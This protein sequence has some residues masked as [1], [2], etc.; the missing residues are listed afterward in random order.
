[1]AQAQ[2]KAKDQFSL[3]G[4]VLDQKEGI[5]YLRYYDSSGE[6]VRD[7]AN[8]KE[9]KFSFTGK[10]KAPTV[11]SV[12]IQD[13]FSDIFI[14]PVAMSGTFTKD[15]FPKATVRGSKTQDLYA[16][17]ER[18]KAAIEAKYQKTIDLLR[19]EARGERRKAKIDSLREQ[20]APYF[21]E[22][23]QAEYVFMDKHPQSYITPYLLKMRIADLPIDSLDM[24]YSRL[25]EEVQ[26]T[27][28]GKELLKEIEEVRRGSTDSKAFQF[29]SVGID[30]KPLNL[31]DYQGKYVLLDF[32]G[33]WCA[34]CRKG[35]PH[36]VDLYQEYKDKGIEFISVAC[37]DT[38]AAWRKAVEKDGIGIW[39]HILDEET[40]AVAENQSDEII[41]IWKQYGV[42]AFPTKILISPKASLLAA[43]QKMTMP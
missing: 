43:I 11:A 8:L 30:G 35:H 16:A 19:G 34:P 38:P 4:T 24:Y 41:S 2:Q 29:S 28:Y 1:M 37:Q 6:F 25:G 15:K 12:D 17:L 31:A 36:L 7:S 22:M 33:S 20:L 40:A 23:N 9:G 18:E 13:S 5:I 39:K 10:I 21:K 14:E 32:W 3:T 42:Q 27:I 26:Q